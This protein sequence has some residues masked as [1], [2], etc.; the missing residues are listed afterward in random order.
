[1]PGEGSIGTGVIRLAQNTIND[2]HIMNY[3]IGVVK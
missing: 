1:M 2:E 3:V